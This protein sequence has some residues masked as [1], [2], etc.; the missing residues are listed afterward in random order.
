MPDAHRSDEH[1]FGRLF[2]QYQP[3][4]YGYVRSLVVGR[5]DAEDLLQETA[6]VLW[7]RFDEFQ[8][9]SNFLAWALSVARYQ[10]LYF[11]QRQRRNVLE[12]SQRFIDVVAADTA[13]ESSRLADL[14]ELLDECMA[15]L[16][17]ADR[18]LFELRYQCDATTKSLAERLGRP[19]STV[20]NAI[21][22]I[23]RLLTECVERALTREE[24]A[25]SINSPL[26]PGEGPGVR[27]AGPRNGP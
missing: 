18:D 21:N 16:A 23:R 3:R 19:A 8:P 24:Q 14:Q 1:D 27:A 6:S 17:K 2:V 22:R 15:R 26:P 4:I 10:V 20:Y 13:A 9:G 25:R 12:F 7:R 5:A 11:R